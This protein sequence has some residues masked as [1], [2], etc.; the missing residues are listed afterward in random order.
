MVSIPRQ[1]YWEVDGPFFAAERPNQV[2][3]LLYESGQGGQPHRQVGLV[4]TK[5]FPRPTLIDFAQFSCP[6]LPQEYRALN[7][8]ALSVYPAVQPIDTIP[9]LLFVAR[10][11]SA[12]NP[13]GQTQGSLLFNF[14]NGVPQIGIDSHR[15]FAQPQVTDGGVIRLGIIKI[16]GDGEVVFPFNPPFRIDSGQRLISLIIFL[17]GGGASSLPPN[18]FSGRSYPWRTIY[19]VVSD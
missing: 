5:P 11:F 17:R 9:N 2:K 1:A 16:G 6:L 8:N 14:T 12:F 7:P 13:W 15:I 4:A 10:D 18:A 3:S 19:H